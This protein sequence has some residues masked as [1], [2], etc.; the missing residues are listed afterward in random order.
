MFMI[1]KLGR[2]TSFYYLK[3]GDEGIITDVRYIKRSTYIFSTI[4]A[5]EVAIRGE[6]F[7][8]VITQYTPLSIN[9]KVKIIRHDSVKKVISKNEVMLSFLI[10]PILIMISCVVFSSFLKWSGF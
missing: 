2:K 1:V 5:I 9:E 7:S 3:D 6:L 8:F 4:H 10:I